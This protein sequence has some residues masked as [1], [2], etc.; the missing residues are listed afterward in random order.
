MCYLFEPP[1]PQT[2]PQWTSFDFYG[3]YVE[4]L[5]DWLDEGNVSVDLPPSLFHASS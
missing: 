3:L 2:H 5:P 4:Y 1:F